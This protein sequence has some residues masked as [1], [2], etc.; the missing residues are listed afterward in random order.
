MTI[1]VIWLVTS[2]EAREI[3]RQ[4]L[5]GVEYCHRKQIIHRD[6]KLEVRYA[7]NGMI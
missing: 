7:F 6:L 3:F 2:Q 4:I 5:A 1:F